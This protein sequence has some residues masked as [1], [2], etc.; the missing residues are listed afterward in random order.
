ELV[1]A[2]LHCTMPEAKNALQPFTRD[3]IAGQAKSHA[4]PR[5]L[6]RVCHDEMER[7]ASEPRKPEPA[8]M[9]K[10]RSHPIAKPLSEKT[11]ARRA[12]QSSAK[13]VAGVGP[14]TKQPTLRKNGNGRTVPA[15][16]KSAPHAPAHAEP[17][18]PEFSPDE[19]FPM[20]APS[21]YHAG[22]EWK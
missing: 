16:A 1:A 21:P 13:T 6:L 10:E 4:T 9:S 19:D 7:A 5:E 14:G 12:S 8:A 2:R 20:L 17:P 15:Q 11:A 22:P 18:A 3:W